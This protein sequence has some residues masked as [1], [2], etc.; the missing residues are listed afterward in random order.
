MILL[1]L[2]VYQL[3]YI[4]RK[5]SNNTLEKSFWCSLLF[6]IVYAA[7]FMHVRYEKTMIKA[8]ESL[9]DLVFGKAFYL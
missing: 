1:G 8:F 6:Y 5:Y 2:Q 9:D 4:L 3:I 7:V